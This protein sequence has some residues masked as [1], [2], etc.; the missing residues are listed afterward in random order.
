MGEKRGEEQMMITCIARWVGLVGAVCLM[1]IGCVNPGPTASPATRY[2]VL[3][4]VIDS[5]M[6]LDTPGGLADIAVG[7]RPVAIPAYL[8]RPQ[9]VTRLTDNALQV[10][11]FSRWAEPLDESI[12][13]V[14]AANLQSLTGSRQ[15]Y[16]LP[17]RRSIRIDVRLTLNVLRFEADADGRVTLHVAWQIR[18]TNDPNVIL[19]QRSRFS[20]LSDNTSADAIVHSMSMTL[21]ELSKQVAQAL[22]AVE[23]PTEPRINNIETAQ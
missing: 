19:E 11:D 14:I 21:A 2:Y 23:L 7:I 9:L 13:R 5:S 12:S 1:I 16:S 17:T 6:R 4:S 3:A 10:D 18:A 20:Q 22:I 15:L 8:D